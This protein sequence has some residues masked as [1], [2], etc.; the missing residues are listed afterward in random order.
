MVY[1]A[2]DKMK[3]V[4]PSSLR[5]SSRHKQMLKESIIKV[6]Q[7]LPILVWEEDGEYKFVT[8]L[9]RYLICQELNLDVF[10]RITSKEEA[11]SIRI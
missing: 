7:L 11:I 3:Y 4:G 10:V 6:G 9:Q 2:T 8:G 5:C 1:I